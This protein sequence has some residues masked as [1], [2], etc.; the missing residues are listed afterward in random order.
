MSVIASIILADNFN[1]GKGTFAR[2]YSSTT[3]V[4]PEYGLWFTAGALVFILYIIV[5][6]WWSL[7]KDKLNSG[8]KNKH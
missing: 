8:G 5:R 6:V 4:S 3:G 1:P 7:R 2:P